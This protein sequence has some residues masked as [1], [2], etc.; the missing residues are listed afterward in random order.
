MTR[1][2]E[3]VQVE[4]RERLFAAELAAAL[5]VPVAAV[6]E[7]E[8]RASRTAWL[9][10]AIV[11][12]GVFVASGV[13]WLR[14]REDAT[15]AQD[16]AAFDPVFPWYERVFDLNVAPGASELAKLPPVEAVSLALEVD[17]DLTFLARQ[18]GLRQLMLISNTGA[19]CSVGL[20]AARAIAALPMLESL[21]LTSG[22]HATAEV[23]RELRTAPKLDMLVLGPGFCL[24]A[25]LGA[26]IVELPKL[27]LLATWETDVTVE[28]LEALAGLPLLDALQLGMTRFD[29]SI[30]GAIAKLRTLRALF[31]LGPVTGGQTV[32]RLSAP[33]M[34][35]LAGMP[36]LVSL[37]LGHCM[38][39]EGCL[40][41]LPP[42]LQSVTIGTVDGVTEAGL[43]SV[44]ALPKLRVLSLQ[45]YGRD[46]AMQAA[47]IRLVRALRL[48]R[49][50]GSNAVMPGE[51]WTAFAD[52]P[53]M[54]NL[55]LRCHQAHAPDLAPCAQMPALEQLSLLFPESLTP[56]SLEPLRKL[57]KFRSL[58]VIG[59][60]RLPATQREALVGCLG[61]GVTVKLQ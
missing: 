52:Q 31:V 16:P 44:A 14:A 23:L 7:P 41:A 38:V 4:A 51:L 40:A 50:D 34:R 47:T 49:F 30:V 56:A 54:R 45:D 28:G 1:R 18:P 33:Q 59:S 32:A 19:G 22:V 17:R 9:A 11:L 36:R 21:A 12:L 24:D 25:T 57:P 3:A 43:Q 27:R 6:Q 13:A 8:A 15:A 37:T 58:V 53:H 35:T 5:D 48:E 55:L 39:D 29:D 2:D 60:G 61:P 20:D 10:A 42:R 26:S 46:A